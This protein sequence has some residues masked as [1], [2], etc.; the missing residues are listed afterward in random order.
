MS[1]VFCD[2]V[3]G[4][5]PAK[6]I[7]ETKNVLAFFDVAPQAPVH[8]LVILKQHVESVAKLEAKYFNLLGEVFE[9]IVKVAKDLNLNGNFRIINNCGKGAGQTVQHI[10]FHVLAG[11]KFD[12]ALA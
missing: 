6:K 1:C 12:E 3:D 7:Y 10:H 8:F 11:R 9:V 4:K 2:I 5:L